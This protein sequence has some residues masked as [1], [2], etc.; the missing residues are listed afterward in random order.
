MDVV[1]RQ[2]SESDFSEW[3][4]LWDSYLAFY[5]TEL[6]YG[7]A[8]LLWSR[9]QDPESGVRCHVAERGGHLIGLVHF[10]PH[11]DTWRRELVCYLQDLYVDETNRGQ[12]TGHQLINSVVEHARRSGWSG[13]YWL[14]AADNHP[15]R[16]S[17]DKLT[18][19]STGFIHYEIE[20]DPL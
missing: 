4:E 7:H 17:Y 14:T 1:I 15:A 2:P 20:T 9:L 13:V 8:E 18:G 3:R 11:Q 16:G 6:P 5:E 19:G 12:G 10:L